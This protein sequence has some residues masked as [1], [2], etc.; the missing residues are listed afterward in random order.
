MFLRNKNHRERVIFLTFSSHIN[1]IHN[2][3]RYGRIMC[4]TL[5]LIYLTTNTRYVILIIPSL[6]FRETLLSRRCIDFAKYRRRKITSYTLAVKII[7]HSPKKMIAHVHRA[8]IS[9]FLKISM[10]QLQIEPVPFKIFS[11]FFTYGYN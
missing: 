10:L 5:V 4:A 7:I 3:C 6:V 2:S 9:K 1:S 8:K 11:I